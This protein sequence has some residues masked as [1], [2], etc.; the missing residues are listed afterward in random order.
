MASPL[1]Q[2]LANIFVVEL[3]R[4]II[5]ASSNDLSL[6]KR[7]VDG[8]IFFIKLNSTNKLLETLNSYHKN[9]KF[10]IEIERENFVVRYSTDM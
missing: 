8:T 10:T 4:N 7:Y 1:D 5:P 2:V 9:I 6:W 3:E